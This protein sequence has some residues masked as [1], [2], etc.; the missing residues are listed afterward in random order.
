[1]F[2]PFLAEL[3]PAR[4]ARVDYLLGLHH[5]STRGA[6]SYSATCSGESLA[7]ALT[8]FLS[9]RPAAFEVCLPPKFLSP[10][11]HGLGMEIDDASINCP[12]VSACADVY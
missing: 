1:V 9:S 12:S 5:A 4:V 8:T 7:H 3:E 6:Y 2:P 10:A 11:L